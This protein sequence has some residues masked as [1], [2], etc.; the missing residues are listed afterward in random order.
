MKHRN[1]IIEEEFAKNLL[2][3]EGMCVDVKNVNILDIY[4][5]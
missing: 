5:K 2:L 3:W 1:F 4:F